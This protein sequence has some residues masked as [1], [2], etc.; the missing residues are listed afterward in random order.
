MNARLKL[1]IVGFVAGA[2]VLMA[3]ETP[4]TSS[5]SS[6]QTTTTTQSSTITGEVVQFQPGQTIVVRDAEGKTQTYTLDPSLT[7]PSDVQVGRR[8]TV[9]SSPIDGSLRVQKITMVESTNP[10]GSKQTRTVTRDEPGMPPASSTGANTQTTTTTQSSS[11]YSTQQ[12]ADP[13]AQTQTTTTKTTKTTTVSGTV[14]AYEP[15][16]SITVVGPG[17]KVTTYTITTDSQL[18]QDVAVGKTVTMQTTMVSG[19]PVVRSVTSKTTTTTK[20]TKSKTLSPQ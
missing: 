7:V 2:S 9:Y 20:T 18:P 12:P 13:S 15:G 3:Q 19:K 6:Q 8:I 5:T 16:Q 4:A 11:A 17:N 14:K 1:A 10:D